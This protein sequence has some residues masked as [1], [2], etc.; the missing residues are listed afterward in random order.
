MSNFRERGKT[1]ETEYSRNQEVAFRIT[2]RRNRLFGLWAAEKMSVAAGEAAEAYAKTVV[3]ADF[4]AP[5]DDDIIAKVRVDLA[6][7]GVAI[8]EAELRA[9][10]ARAAA[11]ARRQVLALD[12]GPNAPPR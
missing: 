1:F 9:E 8:A 11:E 12:A 2:A 5:G 6:A 7:K 3:A 4:E 10:L